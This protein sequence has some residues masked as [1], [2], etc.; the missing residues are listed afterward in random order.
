MLKGK[1]LEVHLFSYIGISNLVLASLVLAV[2]VVLLRSLSS[3]RPTSLS[4]NWISLVAFIAGPMVS[5]GWLA[6]DVLFTAPNYRIAW[7]DFLETY[8]PVLVVGTFAG[9]VASL[10][11][12]ATGRKRSKKADTSI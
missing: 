6:I 11:F 5:V 8:L 1:K 7:L 2:G 3:D 12:M 10:A 4:R 9:A